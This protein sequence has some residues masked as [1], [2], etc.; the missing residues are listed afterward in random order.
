M[1]NKKWL[2]NK[3]FVKKADFVL[4]FYAKIVIIKKITINVNKFMG[5]DAPE[6]LVQLSNQPDKLCDSN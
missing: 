1:K 6:Q 3:I 4:H 2:L 5:R